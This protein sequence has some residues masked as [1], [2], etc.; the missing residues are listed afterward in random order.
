MLNKKEAANDFVK[1]V[2]KRVTNTYVKDEVVFKPATVA[3]ITVL[4]Y[5]LRTQG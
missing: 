4:S 3:K 1:E 2:L 5:P